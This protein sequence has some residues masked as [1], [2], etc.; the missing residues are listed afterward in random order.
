MQV[1]L[2]DYSKAIWGKE[3]KPTLKCDVV[4]YTKFHLAAL[5][6]QFFLNDK[7]ILHK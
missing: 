7:A 6:L 4:M 3:G 1:Y 5:K 2:P